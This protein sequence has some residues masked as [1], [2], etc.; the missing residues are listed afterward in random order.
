MTISLHLRHHATPTIPQ[1]GVKLAAQV[2][3]R[4]DQAVT[5][6]PLETMATSRCAFGACL[7]NDSIVVFGM[8]SLLFSELASGITRFSITAGINLQ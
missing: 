6:K 2:L 1:A 4:G 3:D 7:W 5:L 8:W